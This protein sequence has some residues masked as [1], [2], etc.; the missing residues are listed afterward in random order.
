[1]V[2]AVLHGVVSS[3]RHMVIVTGG[4]FCPDPEGKN[5][6]IFNID[7]SFPQPNRGGVYTY[8]GVSYDSKL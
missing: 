7:A 6:K 2:P 1:M 3:Q 5:K 4:E 8:Q